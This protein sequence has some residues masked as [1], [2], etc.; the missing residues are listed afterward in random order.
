[1]HPIATWDNERS[2]KHELEIFPKSSKL[3]SQSERLKP[4]SKVKYAS[5]NKVGATSLTLL[6]TPY[7]HEP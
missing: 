6:W 3:K 2:N 1:M 7:N 4:L 5:T